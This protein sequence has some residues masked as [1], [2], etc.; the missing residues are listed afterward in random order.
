MMTLVETAAA[1]PPRSPTVAVLYFDYDGEGDLRYLRK[2]LAQ[3]LVTDLSGSDKLEVVERA[4]L[5]EVL[6]ELKLARTD[7]IDR[8][9]AAKIGKLLGA[10]YLVMGGYFD[11]G[12]ALRIDARVV[13][14]E[15]GKIVT[16]VG[17]NGKHA[18]FVDLEQK[19]ATDLLASLGKT[20]TA[21]VRSAGA[22]KRNAVRAP[23]QMDSHT[24]ARYGEALDAMDRGEKKIARA[25][26][27]ELVKQHPDFGQA[28]L[29]LASLAK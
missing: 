27:E 29:D 11:L 23:K 18:Q 10:R 24:A 8:D 4:R 2:G 15:T 1:A 13:E 22:K 6:A 14:V 12:A 7:K 3:M 5:E 19:L 28:A 20:M 26:L 16:S 9:S 17:Q 21:T 25:S